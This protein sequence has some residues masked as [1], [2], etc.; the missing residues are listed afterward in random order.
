ML[1]NCILFCGLMVFL[2]PSCSKSGNTELYQEIKSVDKM[3]FAKMAITKTV[4]NNQDNILGKRFTAYS[5][6]TYSRAYIDLSSLQTEDLV[7]DDKAK[8]V[9]VFL[10]P[11]V[12]ELT[13]RDV[14]MREVYKNVTGLRTQLDEKEITNLKEEG[15]KSLKKEWEE[16]P[17]FKTHLIDAAKRKVRKYF[18]S[19]FEANGYIAS[20]EFKNSDKVEHEKN[21]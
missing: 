2:L 12:A 18:E 3:V 17:M 1:K 11:V 13:G 8:T 16:N 21:N 19:I 20:I 9:K 7:F 15:N 4:Y 14:E 10:P 5:Y 6:D